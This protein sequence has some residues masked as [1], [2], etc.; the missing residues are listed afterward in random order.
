MDTDPL[1]PLR[2]GALVPL[3]GSPDLRLILC[4]SVPPLKKSHLQKG[5]EPRFRA[6]A[7][8]PIPLPSVI[9]F[10]KLTGKTHG[11]TGSSCISGSGRRTVSEEMDVP[12]QLAQGS[13]WR[14]PS[15]S[16]TIS[17]QRRAEVPSHQGEPGRGRQRTS[18][19][20]L[21]AQGRPG[22]SLCRK[23]G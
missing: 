11:A 4:A 1:Y 15:L 10:W 6:K 14:W 18:E 2:A 8:A 21:E 9:R 5:S 13:P 3:E 22:L 17:K 7:A 12:V 16:P 23:P 20:G 19:G